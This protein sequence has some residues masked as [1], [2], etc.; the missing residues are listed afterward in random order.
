MNHTSQDQRLENTLLT[1]K[2]ALY[3]L[4]RQGASPD[5]LHVRYFAEI[6]G[7][8]LEASASVRGGSL[9]KADP[10][11]PGTVAAE[12]KEVLDRTRS[13][14]RMAEEE[15]VP[16][17]LVDVEFRRTTPGGAFA[18]QAAVQT[19]AQ[20]RA[21]E[22]DRQPLDEAVMQAMRDAAGTSWRRAVLDWNERPPQ[23]ALRFQ[24]HY[25]DE[26]GRQVLPVP[27]ACLSTLDAMHTLYRHHGRSI[28]RFKYDVEKRDREVSLYHTGI[29]WEETHAA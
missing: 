14:F 10:T 15:G 20:A 21:L 12:S 2:E 22:K 3:D 26:R 29:D 24:V 25:T 6:D 17:R 5:V 7:P 1:L 27:E 9:S 16:V 13:F 28:Y 11:A 4:V 18:S 19:I 23:Q 8:T